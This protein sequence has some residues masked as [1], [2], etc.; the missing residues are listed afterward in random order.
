MTAVIVYT[1]GDAMVE[2]LKC[3]PQNHLQVP[4]TNRYQEPYSPDVYDIA[5]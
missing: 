1:V 3:P 4:G 2:C 5:A